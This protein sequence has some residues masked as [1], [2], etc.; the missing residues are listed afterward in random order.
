MGK[1]QSYLTVTDQFCGAG[2]S[3]QGVK[4]VA[5]KYN[6]GIEV[7]LALNHWDLA[8]ETH[9][10]NFP[11]TL[12]D[13]TDVSACDPRRYPSTD[14]LITSP[15]C[16]NHSNAQGTK[17]AK[18]Q[19]DLF[20]KGILDPSAERSRATMWDVVR[21]AEV[22][23]YNAIITEN[24]VDA[25]KWIMF[26]AWINAMRTLGYEHKCCFLNSMHFWPTPQSRDRMYVV[27]WKRGNKAPDLNFMPLA[28]CEACGKDVNAVQSWKRN[29]KA[30]KYRSGYVYCC[31][32][33]SKVVEPYYYAAFNCIDWTQPGSRIGDRK[34]PLASKTLRRI[35]YGRKKY[36]TAPFL[37][38][39]TYSDQARG[40]VKD[41][42]Q[43][44]RT[45]TTF[46][47]DALLT[48]PYIITSEHSMQ[49]PNSYVKSAFGTLPTQA[50]RQTVGV[51]TPIIAPIIINNKGKS[52]ASSSMDA[53]AAQTTVI[54]NGILSKE[55][56]NAFLSYYYGKGFQASHISEATATFATVLGA[57]LTNMFEGAALEDCY[58]RTLK[59]HEVKLG[60][61]FDKDYIILG[62]AKEQVRQCGNAVTPPAMEWLF[63]RV[64]ESLN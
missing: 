40:I 7:K 8:I 58:Y 57:G 64:V 22:H 47:T 10:T 28:N 25:R 14:V 63:E 51:V 3:S 12:H 50:T 61:A 36:G 48:H 34:K 17:K 6:G 27:F 9:N 42:F 18:Q 49:E 4:K 62:N 11:N 31:P 53:L 52:T 37:F 13:C 29:Q 20:E 2:G 26:D 33:C 55:P 39:T 44:G 43:V 5:T 35:E 45:Q 23:N 41:V 60:M 54:N 19:L 38:P 32:K 30:Y 24:V 1:K 56:F 21:F 59:P 15:E 46:G 16:T